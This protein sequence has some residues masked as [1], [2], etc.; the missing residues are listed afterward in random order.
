MAP[1][2]NERL[3]EPNASI[4]LV[5]CRGAGKRTLGFLG[6]LHLRR[7]LVTEDHYFE[8]VT[9]LSRGQY[10]ARHG[11]DRFARQTIDVFRRMLDANRTGCIIECGMSSFNQEAQDVLR[12]YSKTHPVVYIH[13]EKEQ[14]ASLM[15]A[16][17]AQQLLEADGTHR[18]CSNFEYYNLHDSATPIAASASVSGT[19]TPTNGRQQSGPSKLLCVQEDFARFLDIITGRGAAKAWLESPFSVAAIPVEFRAYSYALR[20]RL[21]SLV[22]VDLDWDDFEASADCVELIIDHWPDDLMN[23]IARQVALIRRYMGVPIIYHVEENPRGERRRPPEEKNPMDAELLEL[24]L[25]LGVDYISVDLQRDEALVHRV[26]QRRGRSKVIGNFWHM[27]LGA[28]PWQ[29]DRQIENYRRARALGCDIVRM[30]RFCVNDS[31]AEYLDD[32]KKRVHETFPD[33]KPPLVAYDFSV[34]GVRTPLQTNILA[35]VK[36]LG[37]ENGR[38]HLATVSH[39]SHAFEMNFRQFLLDPLQFYVLGSNVSYSLSPAM[40]TAAYDF[41][42]MPHSFRA[43]SCATLDSLNQICSADTFGGACL[44][45]PFKVAVMPQLKV[46]SAH[47]DAIGAVNVLLPLRGRTGAVLDHANARNRAGPARGFFGDNTDWSSILTCLRRAISPRNHVQP[48]KTTALVVG[49]GGMARAAI[50]ALYQ[51]GCRNIFVYNRTVRRATDV[52][53]HF[54]RWAALQAAAAPPTAPTTATGPTQNAGGMCR[55]LTSLSE[56]WPEGFQLPTIVISCVPATS[57]DGNPP[58]DFVM[59]LDWLRSPTGGVVV[60][61]AYEPLV[62]PLVAQMRAV[63]DKMCPSW[64]VVDGLEVVAEMAIEAFELMTGRMAPK[65]IMKEVCRKTWESQQQ[66]RALS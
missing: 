51:L 30:V 38:D 64:V 42:S 31:P 33:P 32:F 12:E 14:I 53:A 50:Y 65:R 16:A 21:S 23:V 7:R 17:D 27:G 40:H 26:L 63:R 5:G 19:S 43:V 62:T 10:L 61:L 25:R 46:R 15:D 13:R 44:T 47:A 60:E 57:V 11:R 49:A 34:L 54:N 48:S 66:R 1:P 20:L 59:P 28:L 4:V 9:G 8:K 37:M 29:D 41:N 39:A 3:F 22:G 6:A 35:P 56:P 24:G 36:H 55:V 52:A 58:A 2:R 18:S 45:A